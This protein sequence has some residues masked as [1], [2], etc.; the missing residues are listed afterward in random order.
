MKTIEFNPAGKPSAISPG[1]SAADDASK[2]ELL[3][4]IMPLVCH[5]LKNKLTPILGYTQILQSQ[6]LDEFTRERL[7]RIERS[8][9]ELSE[10]LN[11]LRECCKST[12][13]E[14]RPG[15]I[16]DVMEEL[17][18][19]WQAIANA[20]GA[21]VV[22]ELA[23][24]LPTLRFNVGG[25]R[26]MLLCLVENA[27]LA[28]ETKPAAMREIRVSTRAGA[29]AALLAVRDNGC[30]M[31]EAEAAGAWAPFHSKFPGHAGL[32]LVVC[33]KVIADHGAS[34]AI[35]SAPGEY[36]EFV[37]SFPLPSPAVEMHVASVEKEPR[38]RT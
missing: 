9:C 24:G 20:A 1:V 2:K 15:D 3:L 30:G 10:S 35:A 12:P 13:G 38:S 25:L 4:G 5:N 33:E 18:P 36:C 8:A 21:R 6:D 27:A 22:L 32:G 26:V 34:C 29:G 17:T 23:A 7:A 31:S 11:T 16:N 37:V 28:L 14:M 19:Q